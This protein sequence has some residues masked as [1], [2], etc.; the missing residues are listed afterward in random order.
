MKSLARHFHDVRALKNSATL[1]AACALLCSFS[2]KAQPT[3][4]EPTAAT[5]QAPSTATQSTLNRELLGQAMHKLLRATIN[6]DLETTVGYVAPRKIQKISQAMGK[7]REATI[8]ELIRIGREADERNRVQVT[9]G[10]YD[11][12]AAQY[13]TTS[14][15]RSYA[16]LP[17]TR[18]F[19]KE[20]TSVDLSYLTLAS[21]DGDQIFITP[22]SDATLLP[23]LIELYPDLAEIRLPATGISP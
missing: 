19:R 22:L 14:I 18:T 7:S 8:A 17:Y 3:V 10:F 2:A 9:T 4:A 23:E 11:L 5:Q 16:L 21:M 12:D 20:G 15:G 1:L 6:R 13:G